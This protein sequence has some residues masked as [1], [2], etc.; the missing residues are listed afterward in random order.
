MKQSCVNGSC[1]STCGDLQ[2]KLKIIDN[3][4]SG[5]STSDAGG[6]STPDETDKSPNIGIGGSSGP[7]EIVTP[8]P[9]AV[10]PVPGFTTDPVNGSGNVPLVL[11]FHSTAQNAATTKW[12]FGDTVDNEATGPD[13]SHTYS[14][15]GTYTVTQTVI[16]AN[17]TLTASAQIYV[18]RV[19][20]PAVADFIA[21]PINGSAPLRVNFTDKSQYTT[22]SGSTIVYNFDGNEGISS[23]RNTSHIYN[24][25]G[26]YYATQTVTNPDSPAGGSTKQVIVTVNEV[27]VTVNEVPVTLAANFNAS[28]SNGVAPLSV[29]FT[30]ASTGAATWEWNF[31]DNSPIVTTRNAEHTFGAGNWTVNLK[32]SDGTNIASKTMMI[33]VAEKPVT[34]T[35]DFTADRTSGQAPCNVQFTDASEGG[36]AIWS[37]DFGDGN[38]SIERNPKHTFTTPGSYDVVLTVNDGKGHSAAKHMPITVTSAPLVADFDADRTGGIDPVSVQFTDNSTGA[39]TWEWNFGDNSPIVTTRNAEHTFG[40]GNWTVNLKVSDGT[41]FASKTM[42]ITVA[43]KPAAPI[44]NFTANRTAGDFPLTVQFFDQ[45]RNAVSY[46]WVFDDGN[47]S[48]DKSP[49]HIYTTEGNYTVTLTVTGSNGE[50]NTS[51]AIITVTSKRQ[52]SD[53]VIND[54]NASVTG[55]TTPFK[56]P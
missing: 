39:A 19:L 25:P 32:V 53:A 48:T 4:Q 42:T 51:Q 34:L 49:G 22:M 6:T 28:R 16:N 45:S 8:T 12:D 2:L 10:L 5:G 27:P 44:A 38:Q 55:N 29:T 31:G 30:D 36:A 33:T 17:G 54:V 13:V 37:W 46:E 40:V 56:S 18:N 43:E 35:A 26:T 15:I 7:N 11:N 3:S 41:N 47:T 1:T 21:V 24:I 52:P 50:K 20:T 23:E 14:A 9:E